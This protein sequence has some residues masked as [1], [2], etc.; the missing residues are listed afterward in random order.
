MINYGDINFIYLST[1]KPLSDTE[2][3]SRKKGQPQVTCTVSNPDILD[4]RLT[5]V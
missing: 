3:T 4:K 1:L 5:S 2:V